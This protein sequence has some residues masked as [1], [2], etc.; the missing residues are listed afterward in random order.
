MRRQLRQAGEKAGREKKGGIHDQIMCGANRGNGEVAK[1]VRGKVSP[2]REGGVS[3]V[4]SD[5]LNAFWKM[6]RHDLLMHGER[7]HRVGKQER[8]DDVSG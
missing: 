7:C 6:H 2:L 8:D 4:N 3:L 5:D 1:V